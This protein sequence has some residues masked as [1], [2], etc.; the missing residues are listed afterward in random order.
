MLRRNL[1]VTFFSALL[2]SA[3]VR[4]QVQTELLARARVFPEVGPGVRAL[5]RDPAGRYCVLAAPG[6]AVLLFNAAGQRVG[7]IPP[8]AAAS[9]APMPLVSKDALLVYG[10]DLDVDAAGRMYIADRGANAVKVFSPA[11]T[12][13]LSISVAAPTSV[14]ALTEAEFAVASMK[15]N[16]LVAVFAGPGKGPGNNG[17]RG[18]GLE[19]SAGPGK[20]SGTSVAPGKVV[21]EFGDATE[22]SDRRDLNRF[23]NIGRLASD[24]AGHI[25]YAFSYLPELTVRKYDR[26]GYAAFEIALTALEFQPAAQAVRR[27]IARQERGGT[28][29]LKPIVTA[30]GVESATQEIWVAL[31][32]LLLHFDREGN[33]RGTYRTFTPEGARLEATTI[34]IEPDRLLIGEDP[35]GVYAFE[36]PEKKT[37]K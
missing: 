21:R 35:L 3:P 7:Q 10:D 23:L 8:L 32:G 33:R 15:S 30:L 9:G 36:R 5:K 18:A 13:E 14:A 17:G 37:Q 11:G 2:L 12:L 6:A 25:Y 16:R 27:E 26:Y 24:S 1:F 31:G 19:N 29:R 4:A 22:I 34:L 28:L 20:A